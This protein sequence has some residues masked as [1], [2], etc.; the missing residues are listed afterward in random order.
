MISNPHISIAK[1][2]DIPQLVSLINSAY[3]GDDSKKGWTTE[4]ELFDG[5]RIN[6]EVL[7]NILSNNDAVMLKYTNS[8][9]AI[10]GCVYL[11]KQESQMYLGLLSVSPDIQA[12]GIG[13]QLLAA[14]EEY[15]HERDC[16]KISMTVITIR[17]ELVEWYQR[18]GYKPT[19]EIK[20]F[21]Q[22]KVNT[23]NQRLELF[24]MEKEV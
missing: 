10:I 19:G 7:T 5:M 18:R 16:N 8:D 9:S 3:R 13:K 11:E 24:V 1:T 20:Q 15:A 23:P 4:A 17:T 6:E 22:D 14:A 2:S 12:S 21:P